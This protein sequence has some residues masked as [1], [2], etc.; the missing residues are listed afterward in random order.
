MSYAYVLFRI[1]QLLGFDDILPSMTLLKGKTK[2]AKQDEIFALCCK[3]LDWEWIPSTA[4]R[5]P[6]ATHTEH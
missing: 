5:Q 6:R 3:D 4:P 2:L 1:C